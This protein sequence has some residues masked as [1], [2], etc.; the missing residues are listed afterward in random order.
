MISPLLTFIIITISKKK[1]TQFLSTFHMLLYSQL[2]H[3]V[4]RAEA[5]RKIIE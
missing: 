5:R 2:A 1:N 3:E 4:A